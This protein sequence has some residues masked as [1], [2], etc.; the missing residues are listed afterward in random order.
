M[1]AKRPSKI[2]SRNMAEADMA[3]AR[4]FTP[5]LMLLALLGVVA[6]PAVAAKVRTSPAQ[7]SK[8]VKDLSSRAVVLL[9]DY[10]ESMPASVER[11]SG[12]SFV[13]ISIWT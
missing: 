2:I 3:R 13:A 8:F 4:G 7:A 9:A 1:Q 10:I 11:S 12:I 5:L 6:A